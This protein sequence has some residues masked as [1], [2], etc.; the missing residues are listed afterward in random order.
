[1]TSSLTPGQ[2]HTLRHMLGINTP[3]DA[4]PKPHRDYAAVNPGDAKFL[5]L[6]EAGAVERYRV[7]GPASPYDYYRCTASGR[8]AAM[9][10][11]KTIRVTKSRRIY[12]KFLDVRD[13][14]QDLTF[15]EFLTHEQFAQ[16][17][18]EA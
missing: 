17:R 7:A 8:A 4:R 15:R 16:T 11:H 2:L 9:A 6:A 18:R 13:A 14:L 3:Y 1:M 12:S 10:S 5:A